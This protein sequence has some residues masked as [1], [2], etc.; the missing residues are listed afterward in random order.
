[1]EVGK[2]ARLRQERTAR[3][4]EYIKKGLTDKEIGDLEGLGADYCQKLK[5]KIAGE[6]GLTVKSKGKTIEVFKKDDASYLLRH[7]LAGRLYKL[8]MKHIPKEITRML[9]MTLAEQRRALEGIPT[10]N[11]TIL[12]MQRLADVDGISFVDLVKDSITPWKGFS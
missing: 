12:Q 11:W 2:A 5:K 4:I 3:F 7:R 6:N 8:Q 10:H 9:G 1:M